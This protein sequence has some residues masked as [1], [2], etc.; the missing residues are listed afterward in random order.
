MSP[1]LL[2]WWHLPTLTDASEH[3]RPRFVLPL[4]KER[5][6]ETVRHCS[7]PMTRLLT[8]LLPESPAWWTADKCGCCWR[9][10][11]GQ[12]EPAERSIVLRWPVKNSIIPP[13]HL[14]VTPFLPLHQANVAQWKI[15]SLQ[16]GPEPWFNHR[17]GLKYI[18]QSSLAFSKSFAALI[19]VA[20]WWHFSRHFSSLFGL[21]SKL[22]SRQQTQFFTEREIVWQ[23]INAVARLI[24]TIS[25]RQICAADF[26]WNKNKIRQQSRQDSIY[27]SIHPP[28]L[29]THTHIADRYHLAAPFT[30]SNECSGFEWRSTFTLKLFFCGFMVLELA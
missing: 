2:T 4:L 25:Y 19:R 6:T 1:S 26:W 30:P 18:T 23:R 20:I 10:S 22:P 17:P 29:Q 8:T 14:W 7:S 27:N 12:R 24:Y 21:I 13:S 28:S 9:M 3:P 5:R 15:S 16:T 11:G